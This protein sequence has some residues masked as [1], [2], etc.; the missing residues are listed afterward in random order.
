MLRGRPSFPMAAIA[1]AGV[2][3]LAVAA[4]GT[5]SSSTAA[6]SGASTATAT[7]SSAST[8]A[9]AG[10]TADPL[11]SLSGDKVA[12]EAI[13]DTKAASSLTMAGTLKESGVTYVLNLGLKSGHQ[14]AGTIAEAG[15]GSFK[16]IVIGN[17]LYLSPDNKFW[18]TYAGSAASAAIALVNG[19]YIKTT[20][21]SQMGS[22]AG[23]CSTSQLLGLSTTTGI[24]KGTVSTLAGTQ[25][26]SL[27]DSKGSMMY[28]T[29]T[30]K[31]EIVEI[32][33]TKD[34]GD[35]SGKV[36]FSVGAPV[37]VV[38]PPSSQVIDGSKIGV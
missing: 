23:L 3:C 22:F 34:T 27:T 26:L 28:V 6:G 38:A 20:T 32:A 15:K 11:A 4:C 13:A 17:T 31:P 19:R 30:S 14:C 29:D 33:K 2:S 5:T 21:G 16:L 10:S 7:A 18:K 8:A 9:S 24:T 25:V 1:A 36:D 35:G 12:A 37:T